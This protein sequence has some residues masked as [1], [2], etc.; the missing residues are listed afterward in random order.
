MIIGR[1]RYEELRE[2][3]EFKVNSFNDILS[4]FI[5][6]G[7]A[8]KVEY[9]QKEIIAYEYAREFFESEK[10]EKSIKGFLR[11]IRVMK[12]SDMDVILS[13]SVFIYTDLGLSVHV[14]PYEKLRKNRNTVI[15]NYYDSVMITTKDWDE[16]A[17]D[18]KVPIEILS[19]YGLSE[20]IISLLKDNGVNTVDI[21][22]SSVKKI[23]GIS[24]GSLKKIRRAMVSYFGKEE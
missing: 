14:F 22:D 13:N 6:E 3:L 15:V 20:R 10:K 21:F 5:H 18:E 8:E 12:D 1:K 19:G 17:F 4:V 2:Y 9:R 16:V 11:M 24:N 7:S 23:K